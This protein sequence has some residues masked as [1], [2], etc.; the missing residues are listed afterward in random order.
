MEKN[1]ILTYDIGTTGNKCT[2]FDGNGQ[3]VM[4]T[5]VPYDTIYPKPGWSE[6]DPHAFW[7]SVVT[8]T[9]ELINRFGLH[10]KDIAVIGISG[11]MNGCIPMDGKGNVLYNNIIH[12]DCRTQSQ[13]AF[14]QEYVDFNSFYQIT[15]NRIDPHYTLPK[16]LWLK[17]NYPDLYQ[18]TRC[19]IN[20]KDY[21]SYCL[22]GNLGITDY[23]DASLTCMLDLSKGDWAYDMLK[24]LG[25]DA[26][27]LPSL[28]SSNETAGGLKKE[29]ADLLGLIPGTPVTV[30]GGD[31]ACATRGSGVQ[32]TGDTY[33]Y[34]GSSSW[35]A[36]LSDAPILDKEARIFNYFDL[37]GK[38]MI[39]CGTVQSA[40]ASYNWAMDMLGQEEGYKDPQE[41]YD[42]MEALARSAPVGSN[43]LFFLPYLMGERTPLW[44]PN[45]RGAFVGFTLY[46]ARSDMV[47]SVYEGVAYALRSVL[48]VFREN[49]TN[50]RDMILI[51]GGAKSRLWNEMLCNI[52]NIPVKVHNSPGVA[53]SLGAAIA[54]GVG[55][56]IFKDY[57]S[58]IEPLFS[59]EYSPIESEHKEYERHYDI[60]KS[61]YPGLKPVYDEI[62]KL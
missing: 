18:Q 51:G 47:R 4:A 16:V 43:G 10:P 42:K 28:H 49:E 62:A 13:C 8:G 54:A 39:V 21:I 33:N 46:H 2:V 27:K 35:I 40:A 45:T 1:Y 6:Q 15:G 17:D 32:N 20:T 25:L 37:D 60:Y 52:F 7:Q 19:F 58:A 38:H 53:T 14:I 3:E 23:S 26:D 24:F 5:S 22:T 44:D 12:S 34:F 50:I 61:I 9:R 48:D 31:G 41:L 29:A 36:N 11:H 55:V 30:G 57:E 56:G 59:R